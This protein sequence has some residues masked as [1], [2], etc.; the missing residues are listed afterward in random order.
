VS[1]APEA[2]RLG[3]LMRLS[4]FSAVAGDK[5]PHFRVSID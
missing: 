2:C 3:C 4:P 5:N 1:N